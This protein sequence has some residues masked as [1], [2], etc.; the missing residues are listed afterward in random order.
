M[1]PGAGECGARRNL[2]LTGKIKMREKGQRHG[3]R[4]RSRNGRMAMACKL[5]SRHSLIVGTIPFTFILES[6]CIQVEVDIDFS[7][8]LYLIAK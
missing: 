4:R 6:R 7:V 2:A 8:E 3:Q 5:A 1:L